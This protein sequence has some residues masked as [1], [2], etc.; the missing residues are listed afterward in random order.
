MLNTLKGKM[1]CLSLLFLTSCAPVFDN[2]PPTKFRT[3]PIVITVKENKNLPTNVVGMSIMRGNV[4]CDIELRRYP[5]C[6]LHEVR[7]C[8]EGKW[9]GDEPNIDDCYND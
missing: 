7:H 1:L 4:I 5:Y 6:L 8:L 3:D 2:P 9:H